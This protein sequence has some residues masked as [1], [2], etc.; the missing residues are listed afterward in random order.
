MNPEE[1]GFAVFVG[2]EFDWKAGDLAGED[3]GLWGWSDDGEVV[4]LLLLWR[5]GATL[6][7]TI[8]LLV[9]VVV[10]SGFLVLG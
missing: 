1:L 3:C 2:E 6:G 8:L 4:V 7:I 9:S 5:R 10:R